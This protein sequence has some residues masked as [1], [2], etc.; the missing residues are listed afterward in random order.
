MLKIMFLGGNMKLSYYLFKKDVE[1]FD[2]II[3]KNKVNSDNNYQEL[4]V[5]TTDLDFDAKVYMQT[6]KSKAPK[7]LKFLE[8][9]VDI[10]DKEEVRN[11]V[12]SFIILIKIIKDEKKY[13]FGITAGFGFIGINKEK[14]ENDFGLKVTLN[15]ISPYELKALDV[16]NIDLKTKQK[17]VH[18]NKGSELG[19]FELDLHQDILNLV[20]G[21]CEDTEVGTNI[22][23]TTSLNLNSKVKFKE[24][25]AKCRQLIELYLS[26][27][28]KANFDFIDNMKVVKIKS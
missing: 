3:L 21:K 10:R 2:E 22:R 19:E 24:L 9:D 5:I 6:N 12:N 17:R 27:K 16:R 15:S 4:L 26:D 13:F 11:T 1:D 8:K 28:Y 23:G 7:W 20:S 14:L 18:I 25:G